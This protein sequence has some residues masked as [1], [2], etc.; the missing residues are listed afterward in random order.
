M[1][2]T[3]RIYPNLRL[4]ANFRWFQLR[5]SSFL[6][7]HNLSGSFFVLLIDNWLFLQICQFYLFLSCR[8]VPLGRWI[9][10]NMLNFTFS[11][12]FIFFSLT[13]PRVWNWVFFA[14]N[15]VKI[16]L[17]DVIVICYR[18]RKLWS[19]VICAHILL[20]WLG[21]NNRHLF[22]FFENF[23]ILW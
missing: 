12:D 2:N 7:Y 6:I 21:Q 13:N 8:R 17:N 11:F 4:M 16:I 18:L 23:N 20:N 3:A 1:W 19:Q 9:F 22:R 15:G 5:N 14:F 10:P